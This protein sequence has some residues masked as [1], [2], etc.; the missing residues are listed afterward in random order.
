[1]SKPHLSL[2]TLQKISGKSELKIHQK[3]LRHVTSLLTITE[4]LTVH[5]WILMRRL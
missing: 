5:L 3:V 1:M 2:Y 4:S